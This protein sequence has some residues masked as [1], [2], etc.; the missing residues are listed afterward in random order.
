MPLSEAERIPDAD[1][2][3]EVHL[4]AREL[5]REV[6]RGAPLLDWAWVERRAA[7]AAAYARA[8]RDGV[9][10]HF[11]DDGVDLGDAAALLLALRRTHA[12][13]ARARV[14]IP[15]PRELRALET[16][17][18]GV[19]ASVAE[20]ARAHAPAAGRPADRARRA[21]GPRRRP[22]RA[23]RASSRRRARR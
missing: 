6:R 18:H 4:I 23:R 2:I 7:E 11:A 21:R 13:R 14:R 8:F 5:E 10:A 1:E 19:V 20:R 3:L 15:A 12:G 17:K 9:L 22:R 16:W